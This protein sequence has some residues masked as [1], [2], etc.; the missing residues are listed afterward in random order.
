MSDIFSRNLTQAC[1][2]EAAVARGEL[3][4]NAG[5]LFSCLAWLLAPKQEDDLWMAGAT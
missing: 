5:A 2:R 4:E 3:I 1:K